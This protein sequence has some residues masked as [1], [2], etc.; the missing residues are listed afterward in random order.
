MGSHR[1]KVEIDVS[2]G[3]EKNEIQLRGIIMTTVALFLTC[4]VSFWLMYVLQNEL[5]DYWK[6]SEAKTVNPMVLK[7]ED[8]LPPVPRLQSAPGFGV[9]SPQGRLNLE[10]KHPQA[11][12]EELQKIWAKETEEGQKVVQNGQETIVT[13]PIEEA[14]KRLLAEGVKTVAPEQANA[15][16][17]EANAYLS[18]ASAGRKSAKRH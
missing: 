10:L 4:V 13:L 18:G 16:I 5:E 12:W 2:K 8:K 6:K 3:Y 14:K 15:A 9:D 1:K 11:E 7:S 17:E